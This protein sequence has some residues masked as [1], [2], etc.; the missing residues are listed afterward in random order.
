V[1]NSPEFRSPIAV[2]VGETVDR[3][4]FLFTDLLPR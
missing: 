4:G 2:E 1:T 3:D